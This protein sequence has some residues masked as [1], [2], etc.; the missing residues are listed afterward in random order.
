[1]VIL[2]PFI[3]GC[4]NPTAV[5]YNDDANFDDESCYFEPG[6]TSAGYLEYYTQGFE[7]DFD[8]GDCQTL[9]VF[10]CTDQDHLTTMKKLTSIMKGVSQKYSVVQIH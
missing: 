3:D 10:G 4:T 6:C 5:N 9:A 2:I 8:N 7:A 1:M